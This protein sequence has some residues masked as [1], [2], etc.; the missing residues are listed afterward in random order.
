MIQ[1][2]HCNKP[3]VFLE[4]HN[5]AMRQT[6]RDLSLNPGQVGLLPFL[7]EKSAFKLGE[8]LVEWVPAP[9]P[10]VLFIYIKLYSLIA[11]SQLNIAIFFSHGTQ[12]LD[13]WVEAL[14]MTH[15]TR[16]N[17]LCGLSGQL[18]WRSWCKLIKDSRFICLWVS[19]SGL[20]IEM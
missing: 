19:N 12:T 6:D 9:R 10:A 14:H 7:T 2:H 5:F 20:C 1:D 3:M 16:T 4:C 17:S 18:R 11:T 15:S 8:P 13:S